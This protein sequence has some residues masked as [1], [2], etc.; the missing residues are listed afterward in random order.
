M[1][2]I[3]FLNRAYN[4]L[5]IQL[6][7]IEAFA[8]DDNIKLR[9][10]GYPCDGDMGTPSAHEAVPYMKS[11]YNNISFETVINHDAPLILRAIYKAERIF[12][13]WRKKKPAKITPIA[14]ILKYIH[15]S[16]LITM[17]KLLQGEQKWLFKVTG[18]WNPAAIIIDE[19]Y[20]VANRSFITDSIL[21]KL[22]EKGV[23]VYMIQTGHNIYKAAMP[24][25]RSKPQ[26]KKTSAP[27]FFMPSKLDKVINCELFP[28]E[29]HQVSGNLRMD[30]D[31]LKKLHNEVLKPPYYHGDKI[32]KSLPE[33]KPK[34]AFMLSK[35]NYGI[36]AEKLKETIATICKMEGVAVTLKPHTRG[37][38]F[39]FMKRSEI[40][41]AVIAPDIPSPLLMEWADIILFT[42]SSVVYHAMLM[43]KPVGFLSFCQN[44]ETVFDAG[45][46]AIALSSLEQL[47]DAITA[48]RD[49]Q[50][51]FIS[52][53]RQKEINEALT[54]IVYA[55][56]SS[57]MIA[58]S[59]KNIILEDIAK[60]K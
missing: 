30:S 11:T 17:R 6:S 22:Q 50:E 39:D 57:G 20:A 46:T 32:I 26:Y 47:T 35:M 41:N 53:D 51:P 23:P 9:V 40:E 21:P 56:D 28:D 13:A 10:I 12:A 54:Q 60:L 58:E 37:M 1:K 24:S 33:G 27:R 4:D 19:V 48:Y 36:D 8:K 44:H 16:L 2:E 25:G 3:I 49:R 31:W 29:K 45:D 14:F 59:H 43:N 38:K 7:L 52:D 15:V 5:D 55:G 18:K 42:G 34:I